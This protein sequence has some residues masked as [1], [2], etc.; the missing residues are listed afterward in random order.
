LTRWGHNRSPERFCLAKG[1]SERLY[2]SS[3]DGTSQIL[4]NRQRPFSYQTLRGP[5]LSVRT[6]HGNKA[7]KSSASPSHTTNECGRDHMEGSEPSDP[8]RS[9]TGSPGA[10]SRFTDKS[11]HHRRRTSRRQARHSRK[12]PSIRPNVSWRRHNEVGVG[13]KMVRTGS[14]WPG[15]YVK[16]PKSAIANTAAGNLGQKSFANSK[17]RREAIGHKV[18]T[19]RSSPCRASSTTRRRQATRYGP[20]K[21]AVSKSHGS[22][23]IDRA[24]LA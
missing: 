6:Y 9:A 13:R 1:L 15:D 12:G 24:A 21:I 19:S 20:D 8:I 5:P 7:K 22:S 14:R 10:S 4:F 17:S 23:R 2:Q 18:L 16:N 11:G 3:P